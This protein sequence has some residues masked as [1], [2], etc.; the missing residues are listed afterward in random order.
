MPFAITLEELHE[1][2]SKLARYERE[3]V[4]LLQVVASWRA[5]LPSAPADAATTL[6]MCIKDVCATLEGWR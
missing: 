3:R 5:L 1:T 2:Q 6:D 4:E